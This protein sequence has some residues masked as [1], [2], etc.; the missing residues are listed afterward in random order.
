LLGSSAYA[1]DNVDRKVPAEEIGIIGDIREF[2]G[3]YGVKD[4]VA[5]VRINNIEGEVA[6]PLQVI[7]NLGLVTFLFRF[8]ISIMLHIFSDF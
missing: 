7:D 6:N 3:T 1:C 4:G 5:T 8:V 2:E